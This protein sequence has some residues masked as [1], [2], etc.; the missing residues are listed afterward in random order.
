M[1]PLQPG[2]RIGAYRIIRQLGAGGMGQ[3]YEAEH[4]ALGVRRAL[5]VFSTE[6]EHSEFLRKRFVAEGRILADLK[7]P[8][9]VRVYDLVVDDDS[10]MAYFE[11]DLV[12]SPNGQ[13]RTLADEKRDGVDEGK[14]AG[15]FKDICEGLAYIHSQGVVH[16]DMSL[17]NILIGTDGHAVITDFG[18]AKITD[19]SFRKRIDM[20]V[21]MVAKGGAKFCMGKGLYMS[22]ELKEQDGE[23]TFAS[24]AYAVGVILFYLLTGAW[25]APGTNLDLLPNFKYD[26]TPVISQLCNAN[27]TE[28]LGEGGIVALPSLLKRVDVDMGEI[29][30]PSPQKKSIWHRLL[31]EAISGAVVWGT[32]YKFGG[33]IMLAFIALYFGAGSER[34]SIQSGAVLREH[35]EKGE[36]IGITL[37]TPVEDLQNMTIVDDGKLLAHYNGDEDVL[38][39]PEGIEEIAIY[40]FDEIKKNVRTLVLPSTIKRLGLSGII[41]FKIFDKIFERTIGRLQAVYFKGPPPNAG[42]D[43]FFETYAKLDVYADVDMN[44]WKNTNGTFICRWPTNDLYNR[45]VIP[46]DGVSVYKVPDARAKDIEKTRHAIET[47]FRFVESEFM[48]GGSRNSKSHFE[49]SFG[50]WILQSGHFNLLRGSSYDFYRFYTEKDLYLELIKGV[51][52]SEGGALFALGLYF[53]RGGITTNNIDVVNTEKSVSLYRRGAD[54]G[55]G[56]CIAKLAECYR[57]GRGVEQNDAEAFKYYKMSADQDVRMGKQGVADCYFYGIGTPIDR[58]KARSWYLKARCE[59]EPKKNAETKD[60]TH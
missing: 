36:E 45:Q 16:R 35:R 37:A 1:E 44:G 43:L 19:D 8:R 6:S 11:M 56:L 4:V 38:Q 57:Y 20:T 5:K 42:S 29:A 39:I 12:L 18:V 3:V 59:V 9:I 51:K 49:K 34:K 10:G 33:I 41:E 25:Y 7:H 2:Q 32:F 53:E 30:K 24:D 28:R 22:P 54:K 55:D 21:T 48:A 31:H 23:A 15:W 60:D 47:A 14:V 52:E 26:W 58:D 46:W 50:F 17:D 40:A 27:P 13:P